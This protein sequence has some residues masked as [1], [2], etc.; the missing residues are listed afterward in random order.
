MENNLEIK[1]LLG[2]RIKELRTK[3]GYTQEQLT[4][5]LNIGQR[6]LSKIERGNT[7]VSA[8][9]LAKLLIALDVSIDELFNFG[10]LQEK[11]VIKE[12]LIDAIQNEKI[13]INTLYRIY[14]SLK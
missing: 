3:K 5:K 8:E 7:F 11:E 1:K 10:Y 12:E 14:K 2:Q 6:T 9:T 13:D 4:E